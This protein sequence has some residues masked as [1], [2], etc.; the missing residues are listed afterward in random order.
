MKRKEV[1]ELTGLT[2]KAIE[3]YEEKELINP[4]R[5]EN[6]YRIYSNSHVEILKKIKTLRKLGLSVEEITKIIRGEQ[7]SVGSIL[8]KREIE[9]VNGT[10][11]EET[12]Y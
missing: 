10:V 2:R 1:Q 7:E 6:N 11:W 12:Q 4:S 8:R 9:L 5:D 3:Y